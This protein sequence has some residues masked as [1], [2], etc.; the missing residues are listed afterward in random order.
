MRPPP[1]VVPPEPQR[2]SASVSVGYVLIPFVVTDLKG[3]TRRDLTA[4]D[5][6]LTVDGS[7]VKTDLFERTESAAVSFTILLDGSG[8]MGLVGKMDGARAAIHA[9]LDRRRPGDDYALHVFSQGAV[10][11]TVPFTADVGRIRRFVQDLVPFGRTALFDAVA[12]TP[13]RTLLGKNGIRAILL[14][15]DGIDNASSLSL[16]QLEELF[17]GVDVPVYPIG[18]RAAGASQEPEP[19]QSVEKL[20][21]LRVLGDLARISGGRL[22]IVDDPEKLPEA[23]ADIEQDLRSQYV[24]GFT[25]TGKGEMKFR[26]ISLKINGPAYRLRVRAGYRGTEPPAR[27]AR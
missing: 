16:D 2:A 22:A 12:R 5:V 23:I 1:E 27:S 17:S 26:R 20:M 24:I 19:G 7:P 25:P 4:D 8:S 10:L 6:T 9:L 21:N 11:E 13:D 14:L 18:I 3:R 15:T